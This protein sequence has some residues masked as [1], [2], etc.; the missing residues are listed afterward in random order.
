MI[1]QTNNLTLPQSPGGRPAGKIV[2]RLGFKRTAVITTALGVAAYLLIAFMFPLFYSHSA[3]ALY[4]NRWGNNMLG[5]AIGKLWLPIPQV[6]NRYQSKY[7]L[8]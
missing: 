4:P 2:A 5:I 8:K 1:F 3:P 7:T 6:N